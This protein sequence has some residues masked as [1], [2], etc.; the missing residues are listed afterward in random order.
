[1]RGEGVPVSTEIVLGTGV[2]EATNEERCGS[3]F[4]HSFPVAS[5]GV[6]F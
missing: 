6:I 2:L 1:M 4:K 5:S 3:R